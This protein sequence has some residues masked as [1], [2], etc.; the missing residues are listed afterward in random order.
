M[1]ARF[2]LDL[3]K[4][5]CVRQNALSN[6]SQGCSNSAW[7]V[8]DRELFVATMTD[9][10][11]WLRFPSSIDFGEEY[12]NEHDSVLFQVGKHDA[13]AVLDVLVAVHE[14][15]EELSP[16]VD[17]NTRAARLKVVDHVLLRAALSYGDRNAGHCR[18]FS[19]TTR[20][21]L[22]AVGVDL[23]SCR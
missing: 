12:T 19:L 23:S 4:R 10:T 20:R 13:E 1:G 2:A 6:Y 21:R 15:A 22:E 5:I 9:A 11:L 17:A 7:R 14:R 8:A 16:E 3:T 18:L